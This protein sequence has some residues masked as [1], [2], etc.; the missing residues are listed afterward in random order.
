MWGTVTEGRL[1]YVGKPTAQERLKSLFSEKCPICLDLF[2]WRLPQLKECYQCFGQDAVV[3]IVGE[4]QWLTLSF[5]GQQSKQL[6]LSFPSVEMFQLAGF[7][8]S[9]LL[10]FLD[11]PMG[12]VSQESCNYGAS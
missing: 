2:L 4:P 1:S 10:P 3:T 9:L 7:P 6:Q 12:K 5:P 8:E 11:F